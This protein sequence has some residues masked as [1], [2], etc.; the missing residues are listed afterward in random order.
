MT[1]PPGY[2]VPPPVE[3]HS[4]QEYADVK[5]DELR[6]AGFAGKRR[7]RSKNAGLFLL[8][9]VVLLIVSAIALPE[10][11]SSSQDEPPTPTPFRQASR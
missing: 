11:C 6:K 9:V 8:A 10:A 7:G 4:V 3:P 5:A 2:P 1:H